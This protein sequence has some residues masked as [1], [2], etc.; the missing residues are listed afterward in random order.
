MTNRH[1]N[2]MDTNIF[3]SVL[4]LHV[5]FLFYIVYVFLSSGFGLMGP[6][7]SHGRWVSDSSGTECALCLCGACVA[8][9][10]N[11][12]RHGNDADPERVVW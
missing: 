11:C 6:V 9:H 4:L 5:F 2:D 12:D 3:I 8:D 1:V 7:A 10:P